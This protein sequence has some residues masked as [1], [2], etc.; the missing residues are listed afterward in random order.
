MKQNQPSERDQLSQAN[1]AKGGL[2][3][4]AIDRLREQAS[5]QGTDKHF[6]TSDL[7]VNELLLTHQCGFEPLGQVM[8]SSVYH[9]GW[10]AGPGWQW[11]SG[12]LTVL[13]EA[14]REARLLAMSRLQQE[15]QLLGADGVVGVRLTQTSYDWGT[16]LIEF[17]AIGTAVREVGAPPLVNKLP[18]V[19]GLSGQEHYA[20]RKIGY[21]PAGYVVGNCTWFQYAS[22]QTQSAMTGM[23]SSWMNQE[24]WDFTQAVYASRELAMVR[25]EFESRAVNARGIVGVAV[26]SSYDMYENNNQRGLI[27]HFTA[28]GTCVVPDETASSED[29]QIEAV[30]PVG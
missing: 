2:P 7:S 30:V 4:N 27:L 23:F 25:M 24:L 9:V 5:K 16:G 1:V 8:G 3:L 15:A 13:T 19:S 26:D 22:W 29:K 12:E 28:W 17:M 10:Y 6:F 11:T 21:K 14:Y 18:F 20:L